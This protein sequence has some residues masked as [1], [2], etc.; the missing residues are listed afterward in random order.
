MSPFS[1]TLVKFIWL[2]I[3]LNNKKKKYNQYNKMIKI[4]KER[5][6]DKN[7]KSK[8]NKK[9]KRKIKNKNQRINFGMIFPKYSLNQSN[10][11]I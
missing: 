4:R 10:I 1:H 11:N 9:N 7:Q 2:K 6:V 5:R 8:K 3:L